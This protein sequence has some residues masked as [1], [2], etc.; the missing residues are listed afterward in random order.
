MAAPETP[1]DQHFS[2]R[3]PWYYGWNIVAVT[4]LFQGF[5]IGIMFFSFSFWIAPFQAEFGASTSTILVAA[6]AGLVGMGVFAPIIGR[7]LDSHSIRLLTIIGICIFCLGLCVVSI[8]TAVWQVIFVY[9]TILP[10]G[11]SLA[12][13]LP[14]QVV[15]TR[16]FDKKRGMALGISSLGTSIGG[17]IFPPIVTALTG[18]FGW[19]S[20]HLFLALIC[21]IIMLPTIWFVIRERRIDEIEP[22]SIPSNRVLSPDADTPSARG[23]TT[24][25]IIR[26]KNLWILIG[27]ISPM[28]LVFTSIQY[29]IAPFAQEMNIPPTRSAFFMST[30]AICMIFGKLFFGT[31][32]D[33]TDHRYLYW[34]AFVIMA[35]SLVTL[36]VADTYG[37]LLFGFALLGLASG[38]SMPLMGTIIAS[39]FGVEN[40]GRVAGVMAPVT[41]LTSFGPV[42]FGF[43]RARMDS[44]DP[45]FQIMLL[46]LIFPVF[47]IYFL[48]PPGAY[49]KVKS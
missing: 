45:L 13:A 18:E 47:V 21:A 1:S 14:A 12:G 39:R 34:I 26:N 16:W 42:L 8:T 31:M 2:I 23:L 44:Y 35:M 5:T 40:F 6:T 3:T 37:T 15:T 28:F 19:R 9:A 43:L 38:S 49:R 41:T 4:M 17:F 7:L 32:A 11:G 24:L 29:N 20:A 30:V 10:I 27:A 48:D 33:R 46:L 22:G 25:E 36:Q